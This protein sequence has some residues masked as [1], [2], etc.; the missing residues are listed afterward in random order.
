MRGKNFIAGNDRIISAVFQ[1]DA[2]PRP[3]RYDIVGRNDRIQTVVYNCL[4]VRLFFIETKI[5]QPA[6]FNVV[7][8]NLT[9]PSVRIDPYSFLSFAFTLL[10][11][12]NLSV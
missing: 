7:V 8:Y 3:F 1:T 2:T 9:A 6:L 11:P 10:R 12:V 4:G 5:M